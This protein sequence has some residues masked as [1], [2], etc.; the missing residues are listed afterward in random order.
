MFALCMLSPSLWSPNHFHLIS[1]ITLATFCL[2]KFHH[3]FSAT[4]LQTKHSRLCNHGTIVNTI[5]TRK[6]KVLVWSLFSSVFH[7]A[8]D[9]FLA[10]NLPVVHSTQ[11]PSP[12]TDHIC[13][14][15]LQSLIASHTTHN[16]NRVLTTMCHGTLSDFN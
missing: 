3:H 13:H 1:S 11:C 4:V 10:N 6:E 8:R 14:H 5:P 9:R 2:L 12:I 15:I 16:Q 7:L